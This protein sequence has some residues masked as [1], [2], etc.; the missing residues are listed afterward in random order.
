MSFARKIIAPAIVLL[1]LSAIGYGL[2]TRGAQWAESACAAAELSAALQRQS[3]EIERVRGERD[4]ANAIIDEL[5]AKEPEIQTRIREVVKYV[6]LQP[7]TD[8]CLDQPVGIP[9]F[10]ERLRW[11]AG[12]GGD[13]L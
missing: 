3:S 8:N 5:R 9:D 2:Y 13:D 12:E 6:E 4:A 10:V 11:A 1:A 7:E